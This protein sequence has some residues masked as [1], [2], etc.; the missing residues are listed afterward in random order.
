MTNK[1]EGQSVRDHPTSVV[2][3]PEVE[4]KCPQDTLLN[5]VQQIKQ[6]LLHLGSASVL[7][8]YTNAKQQKALES[9]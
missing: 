9:V 6:Q 1:R 3:L 2:K 5:A 4:I 8:E 7:F